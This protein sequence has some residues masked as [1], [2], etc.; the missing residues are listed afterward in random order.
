MT[1]PTPPVK[2]GQEIEVAVNDLAFGGA[3]VARVQG[4]TVFVRG[5]LPGQTVRARIV[6]RKDGFAEA[7]IEEVLV[8][9]PD[10]IA[11]VCRHFGP[12][13]GC[14]WQNLD[15]NRQLAAKAGQVRDCLVRLGGIAEPPLT[16]PLAAPAVYGYR[17]KMEFSFADRAWDEPDC[18]FGVGLHVRGRFDKVLNNAECHIAAPWMAEVLATVRELAMA[19]GLPPS[20]MRTHEGFF[21]FLVL[22][23]GRNTGERMAHLITWPAAPG[24]PE[25][26]AVDGLL[27]TVVERHPEMTSLLHGTTGSKASV[28]Y[29]ETWRVV[30]GRPTI[31]ERL[32][33]HHFEIGPNT[34]FQT[35]TAQAERLFTLALELAGGPIDLAWDLYCGV[36][37]L[38]LPLARQARRVVGAELIEGSIEAA[39]ANA[40]ANGVTNA[41]FVAIDMKDALTAEGLVDRSGRLVSGRPGLVLV[42][43]PRD[44]LHADVTAGLNALRPPV[45]VYVSCNPST[46]ARDAARLAEGGYGMDTATPVDMF[47][48]TAHVEMVARFRRG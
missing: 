11:P 32:L 30:A 38:T 44:G 34:F 18:R 9:S 15:Y 21:R 22:R 6:K 31:R 46:L 25:E 20:Q 42:D 40:I 13:G 36:G 24:S 8:K 7:R 1:R 41:D 48:Q 4:F 29:C 12:C 37:A 14:L 47:P 5:G 23:D 3:G 28:A 27:A 35:N 26:R 45:I 16:P 17:N 39:R 33:D 10:E 2:V 43:P 19:S